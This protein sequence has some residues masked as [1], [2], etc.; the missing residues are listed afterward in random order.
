MKVIY[1]YVCLTNYEQLDT[2]HTNPEFWDI[3]NIMLPMI[4]INTWTLFY[5]KQGYIG[6]TY[7]ISYRFRDNNLFRKNVKIG[8][9]GQFGKI[10]KNYKIYKVWSITYDNPCNPNLSLTVSEITTF[11]EKMAKLTNLA[12]L[13]KFWKNFKVWCS[14][15]L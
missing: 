5:E 10:W 8:N 6:N 11:L 2:I 9:F 3:F 13:A 12:N 1:R 4:L 7:N 14:Y 15:I